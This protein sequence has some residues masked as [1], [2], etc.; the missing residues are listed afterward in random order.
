MKK[1]Y[2]ILT[3]LSVVFL[4][5]Q[6][7]SFAQ[8]NTFTYTGSVQTFTVPAG[9]DSLVI[10][11]TGATGGLNSS[12]VSHPD[13]P[14]SGGCA[15]ATYTVT[16]GQVVYVYVG[17]AGTLATAGFTSPGGFNGGG[18]G[19]TV[20]VASPSGGGG[21]G[22]SDVRFA[23]T[24]LSNRVIVAA[25]GGGAGISTCTSGGTERGGYGGSFTGETGIASCSA[26]GAGSLGGGGGNTTALTGGAGGTCVSCGVGSGFAGV[27]GIGGDAKLSSSGGGGGGGYFGGGGGY[28]G[29]GGGGSNYFAPFSIIPITNSFACNSGGNGTVVITTK[30][31]PS[32]V[33]ATATTICAGG[34]LTVS[35]PVPGG[36]W[37]SS[38]SSIASVNPLTG[39]VSGT[40][41]DLTGGTV[42]ITYNVGPCT[43]TQTITV[44]AV[45]A[46]ITGITAPISVCLGLTTPLSDS[47]SG[48]AWTFSGHGSVNSLGVFSGL[49][50]GTGTVTYTIPSTSCFMT[51]TTVVNPLPANIAGSPVVCVGLIKSLTD[52]TTLG[53]WTS[54]NTNI[55][56]VDPTGNV[57]GDLAGVDT[58]TYTINATGCLAT[59]SFT[60]NPLP[61]PITGPNAL[62]KLGTILL[63]DDSTGGG[64][65][66]SNTNV[67]TALSSG[68]ING[69]NPGTATITYTLATGCLI[70]TSVTVN[71]L[72]TLFITSTTGTGHYCAGGS[73]I[74]IKL[75]GSQT[76]FTYELILGGTGNVET[77]TG[78][79]SPLDFGLQTA[80]G[81]YTIQAYDSTLVTGCERNMTGSVTVVIDPLPAPIVGANVVCASSS[82]NLTDATTGGTWTSSNT[83]VATI[84]SGGVMSG[85]PFSKGTATITYQLTATGCLITTTITEN[86][87]YPIY[88]INTTCLGNNLTMFD[89]TDLGGGG[90]WSGTGVVDLGTTATITG[91]V[92]T[93]TVTYTTALGCS[94]TAL[95]IFTPLAPI[96]GPVMV[97]QGLNISLSNANLGGTWSSSNTNIATVGTSGTVTGVSALINA[98]VDTITYTLGTG[99]ASTYIV[100]V[101]PLPAPIAGSHEVC[102]GLITPLSDATPGGTWSSTSG[103][104]TASPDLFGNVTGV[105][106]GYDPIT[107][108]LPVT[109]CIATYTFTVEPLP[110]A[111]VGSTAICIGYSS[112]LSDALGGTWT[113]S[114]TS[115]AQVNLSTGNVTDG[116]TAGTAT[117][118]YTTTSTGCITTIPFTVNP[119]PAAI[120]GTDTLCGGSTVTLSDVSTGTWTTQTSSIATIDPVTG[121]VTANFLGFGGRDSIIFTS[122]V[123]CKTTQA[124]WVWPLAPIIAPTPAQVCIGSSITLSDAA[125]GGTWES[126]DPTIGSISPVTGILT[127]VAAGSI[128]ITDTFASGCF[129]QVTITVNP[130][131]LPITG[132]SSFCVGS[133]ITLS[134][135]TGGGGSWSTTSTVAS[136]TSSGGVVTGSDPGGTATITYTL[137]GSLC[138]ATT[139]VTVYPISPIVGTLK[140]CVGDSTTLSDATTGGTWSSTG[141]AIASIG[142]TTGKVHAISSGTES[143][144]YT[145]LGGCTSIK[146]FT[147]NPT[148]TITGTPTVCVGLST[149]LTG[150]PAG[151]T[152]LSSASGI[153]SISLGPVGG[154]LLLGVSAGGGSVGTAV[155]TYTDPVGCIN[156]VEAFVNPLPAAIAGP[157]EICQGTTGLLIDATPGGT[158]ISGLPGIGTIGS[159][160][161]I[162]GGISGGTTTITYALTI[163][164]CIITATLT[165]DPIQPI[166]GTFSTCIGQTT[167]LGDPI[168]GGTWSTTSGN[169]AVTPGPVGGGIVTGLAI[170]GGIVTYTNP[171]GCT[172]TASVQVLPLPLPITGTFVLCQGQTTV[173]SDVTGPGTWSTSN[174]GVATI[175]T[176]T[177]NT[178]TLTGKSGGTS[179]ITYAVGSGCFVTQ[180]VTINPI[181]AILGPTQVCIGSSITVSDATAGGIWTSSNT[182]ISITNAPPPPGGVIT[183]NALGVSVITYTMPI[184]GCKATQTI[185]VN[186][187]P[188]VI[189]GPTVVCVNAQIQLTDAT[190]GGTWSSQNNLIAIVTPGPSPASGG[191]V[192]G[193]SANTD[194]ITYTVSATGCFQTYSIT[195]LP[196]PAAITG[197][198]QLCLGGTTQLS[199]LSAGGTWASSNTSV[200][201]ITN[202]PPPPGGFVTSRGSLGTSTITYAFTSTGCAVTTV[203]TVSPFPTPISG[204]NE[205][206]VASSIFLSDATPGG[207]WTSENTNAGAANAPG[208]GGTITG[209]A[210]GVATIDYTLPT[211]CNVL[212]TVTVLPQPP[213]IITPLSD[214]FICPGGNVPLTAN[215]GTLLTYQWYIAGVPTVIPG[216]T[217]SSYIAVPSVNTSYQVMIK[218]GTTGCS[219]ISSPMLVSIIPVSASISSSP[220]SGVA[221]AV[222][223][224]AAITLTGT[225]TPPPISGYQWEMSGV[226][227]PGATSNTYV[228]SSS[229]TYDVVITNSTGCSA[230]SAFKSVTINPTPAGTV[231]VTGP[232]LICAGDSVSM[233]ADAGTGYTYQ[234]YDIGGPIAGAT[235]I[236]YEAMSAGS[237]HVVEANSFGCTA[238]SGTT[239]VVVNPLPTGL[240]ITST[241][242]L[243]FCTG[244]LGTTLSVTSGGGISTPSFQWYDNGVPV[245][246]GTGYTLVVTTS[247]TFKALVTDGS[248]GC[249]AFSPADV[250]TL[251]TI[252]S[253]STLTSA[254]F[255]W[256]GSATLAVSVISGISP[257][258]QWF[259]GTTAI[260]GATNNMYAA[261]VTGSY[262]V[263]VTVPT[264]KVESAYTSVTENPLPDPKVTFDG[265]NFHTQNFFVTYQWYKDLKA[266]AGAT[267][268]AVPAST[269]GQYKVG[270]TD[271]NGCQ[272]I[273]DIYVLTGFV[274]PGGT[275][276]TGVTNVNSNGQISIY[277][278]PAQNVVHIESGEQVRA[279][280]SAMDGK[281][282]IEQKNATDIDISRLADGIYNIVLYNN[283]GD[284]VKVDK[285]VKASN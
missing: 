199:D 217:N 145:T 42:T 220:S 254:S 122:P 26:L 132:L 157:L 223:V 198:T 116:G 61:D 203:V 91:S 57:T 224:G 143:I 226:P 12:S 76:G 51:A 92:G 126:S 263:Q 266:I 113:S 208:G 188:A 48:G 280:I 160:S 114:N 46:V 231:T 251:I 232:T 283:A 248:T 133:S 41:P 259:L 210:G 150:S 71:P 13:L 149:T 144:T 104:T 189:T 249:S 79:G 256:G 65:S 102:L 97:C 30:C 225:G 40:Y 154:G 112:Q 215:T 159:T 63:T 176:I 99:C 139:T 234:W 58:I 158:W 125:F 279:V 168:P 5:L 233:T 167:A 276:S 197:I 31:I 228:P 10:N 121:F 52:A 34:T 245:V 115:V 90:A 174:S 155:I 152:W 147:V 27:A 202:S 24:A 230:T 193:K 182:V 36:T 214:T 271:T 138:Y 103:G 124:I 137:P 2:K 166:T 47:V 19:Q 21:G 68:V 131:P 213:A 35:D 93:S 171:K 72:P 200:A 118:T 246:G 22:A 239:V 85:V 120:T 250:T 229:G 17:G 135:A 206:C 23:G 4:G 134:D 64:W 281:V 252:P 80:A 247:G 82:V 212:Y 219:A 1:M 86:P 207:N 237:Y 274:S 170:P 222:G 140:L 172:I 235:N 151:G 148:P 156:E 142:S 98:G 54:S 29:G 192:T 184:T 75:S 277:P 38:N 62:C 209:V 94:D 136:V 186:P 141:S 73:G 8:V 236:T 123:G 87:D 20:G 96:T 84:N 107:Y 7:N 243:V 130:L 60:V 272:S 89:T 227:I 95:A 108:T 53:S 14:G 270:V 49:T 164:G 37:S 173:L 59:I 195:V 238:T 111:I 55:S 265:T 169:I 28:F 267:T 162:T 127:G 275:G 180:T 260:T 33:V 16:P 69:I 269:N 181:T 183:T 110:A 221:C 285:L 218:A 6:T 273:S 77:K 105:S 268:D 128:T 101:E 284:R 81:T 3:L 25:G 240:G 153:A 78:T 109:G 282:L 74:D 201:T 204:P 241:G 83:A 9:V 163:T 66:S 106:V 211:G 70:T 264:C 262:N 175:V 45:P 161:G 258:Y 177:G 11:A 179:I 146:T 117:I 129:Q 187:L 67:A 242:P 190:A 257:T 56:T 191:L 194:V 32:T 15:T 88:G 253:V 278:N 185:T 255:C 39:L 205:V 44:N 100:T 119:T 216:A 18:A 50:A 43:A 178:G 165:V 196:I 244:S 261:T